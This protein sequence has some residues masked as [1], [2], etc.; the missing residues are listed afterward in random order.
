MGRKITVKEWKK[1][2]SQ[3][4]YT[5]ATKEK[6]ILDFEITDR[7]PTIALLFLFLSESQTDFLKT[8]YKIASEKIK[9]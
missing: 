5:I 3:S 6:V 9:Q 8:K 4:V 2:R 1:I 7:L